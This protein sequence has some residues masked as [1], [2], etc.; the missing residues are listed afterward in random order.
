[1][2]IALVMLSTFLF[3]IMSS[4]RELVKQPPDALEIPKDAFIATCDKDNHTYIHVYKAD[5]IYLYYIDDTLQDDATLDTILQAAYHHNH[6]MDNYLSATF[7]TC[8]II[9]YDETAL[10]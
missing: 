1:M 7:D 8:I 2:K 10:P 6:S 9:P 5:G 4:C 3:G